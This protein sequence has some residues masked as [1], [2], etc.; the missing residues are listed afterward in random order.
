MFHYVV[1]ALG[2]GSGR[3][4]GVQQMK[5]PVEWLLDCGLAVSR[6]QAEWLV[7]EQ[8]VYFDGRKVWATTIDSY[9]VRPKEIEIDDTRS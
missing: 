7:L 9:F 2:A 5:T 8:R 4:V 1:L 6:N 3:I